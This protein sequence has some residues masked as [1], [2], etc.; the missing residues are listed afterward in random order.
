MDKDFVR[1]KILIVDKLNLVF[2]IETHKGQTLR[3][4]FIRLCQNPME[5]IFSE[6]DRLQVAKNIS[7]EIFEGERVGILGIN[8][9][10]KTSLCRCIAGMYRATSGKIKIFGQT[11]AIFNTQVG[12]QPDLTGRENAAL[13]VHFLYIG[14]DK[15]EAI[16]IVNEALEFSELGRFADSPFRVYSN[17]MQ[18]RLSLSLISARGS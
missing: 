18:A 16:E 8:G 10:G 6:P 3:D 5:V 12:I 14:I 11:R 2:R 1:K 9:A 17:G 15:C 7:F 13:L 4:T